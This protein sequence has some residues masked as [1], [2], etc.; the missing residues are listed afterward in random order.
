[1]STP[2]SRRWQGA[3]TCGHVEADTG[4]RWDQALVVVAT[5]HRS[6]ISGSGRQPIATGRDWS[7]S[8]SHRAVEER[9][10]VV[11]RYVADPATD[12]S[13]RPNGLRTSN[14]SVN[15]ARRV[16]MTAL[17]ATGRRTEALRSLDRTHRT[18]A[19]GL[20]ISPGAELARLH[21][22]LLDADDESEPRLATRPRIGR[23]PTAVSSIVGRDELLAQLGTHFGHGRL[24]T[25]IGPGGVGKTRLALE[26][27]SR[28]RSEVSGG[29][30]WIDLAATRQ[31]EAVEPVIA[32]ALGIA[33]NVR[34]TR[35]QIVGHRRPSSVAGDR[36]LRRIARAGRRGRHRGLGCVPPG[37]GAGH[38]P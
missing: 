10:A 21:Q 13:P 22:V 30:W 37:R 26:Y 7:R 20:G 11:L 2:S 24:V 33:V 1:M 15:G 27:A 38:E 5:A 31:A 25:L 35:E 28:R 16:L 14:R 18:L 34:T 17:H 36:Q 12:A 8:C 23:L 4:A 19:T 9:C 29:G 3:T 6:T 32:S